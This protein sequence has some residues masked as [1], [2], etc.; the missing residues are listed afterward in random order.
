MQN[1]VLS[2][3]VVT[4]PLSIIMC[5]LFAKT[6]SHDRG[7]YRKAAQQHGIP[8]FFAPPSFL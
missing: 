4:P 2:F 5:R 7:Q 3:N 6:M 8:L 1:L